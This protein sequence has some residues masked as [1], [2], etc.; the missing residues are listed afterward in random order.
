MPVVHEP[1]PDDEDTLSGLE[2]VPAVQTMVV[3][4]E[5]VAAEDPVGIAEAHVAVAPSAP[6]GRRSR[7]GLVVG[8]AL[9]VAAAIVAVVVWGLLN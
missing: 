1:D 6:A 4:P 9:A 3:P 8:L 5:E 7:R 2:R